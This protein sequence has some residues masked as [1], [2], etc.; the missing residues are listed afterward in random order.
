MKHNPRLLVDLAEA[1]GGY[2]EVVVAVVSEG[3]YADWIRAEASAQG[4][5]NLKSLPL[6]AYERMPEVLSAASVLVALLDSDAGAFSVPSKVLSYLCAARPLLLS[7]PAQNLA[8]RI[9]S[10]NNAGLVASADKPA[11]MIAAAWRFYRDAGLR[12]QCG[13]NAVAWARTNFAIEPIAARFNQAFE[14][15]GLRVRRRIPFDPLSPSPYAEQADDCLAP[16]FR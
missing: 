15:A 8:A 1:M 11:A 14:S 3:V 7:V 10:D 5:R 4:L 13:A 2:P 6:Q 9:V 12:A 16:R